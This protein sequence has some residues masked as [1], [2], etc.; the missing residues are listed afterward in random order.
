MNA[1]AEKIVTRIRQQGP[2]SFCQFMEMAL[3]DPEQGYYTRCR[4]IGPQGDYYTSA[5]IHPLFGELLGEKFVSLLAACDGL[6]ELTIV[7]VGAGTG[8]LA[9]DILRYLPSYHP[10]LFEQ[11]TYIISELSPAFRIVQQQ[12][13]QQ[14]H[15]VQW[16]ALSDLGPESVNGIIFSNELIDA[17]PVHRIMRQG[18]RLRELFVDWRDGQFVWVPG[19]ISTPELAQWLSSR[20]VALEEGQIVEVNLNAMD[21]LDLAAAVLRG[22]YL[23]TIDYGE[24]R[25]QLYSSAHREGTLR[26]FTKHVVT[27]NPF[28]R[29]GE[30]DITASVDFTLLIEY[31]EQVGLETVEFKCQRE[32]MLEQGLIER[33][34]G[35]G[36]SDQDPLDQLKSQLAAKH[37][38]MPGALGDH[39]KLLIQRKSCG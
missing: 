13:L 27:D 1:L 11:L 14:F 17:L 4:E 5:N 29:I 10:D 36:R 7:E 22:G 26:C 34:V 30:Q 25:S 15:C 23:V 18:K 38:L 20:D 21:Y 39:F 31:G 3:Y 35:L 37:L 32:F 19:H 8:H 12:R 2:I 16:V 28:E 33:L 6:T 9:K 24:L